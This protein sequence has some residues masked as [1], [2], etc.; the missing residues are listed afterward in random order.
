MDSIFVKNM[1][2]G[3]SKEVLFEQLKKNIEDNK[4]D[5]LE[6]KLVRYYRLACEAYNGVR[7]YSGEEY[8]THTLNVATILAE[9]EASAEQVL[10]GLFCDVLKK[11]NYSKI[12]KEI[13]EN[14]NKIILKLDTEM[15]PEDIQI[16]KIAERLHN[17]RTIEYMDISK[18]V[19]KAKET[20]DKYMP[21][22]RKIGNQ[23]LID[24]LNDLALKY[25]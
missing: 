22:A 18:R 17:M 21:I 20:L 24:E 15:V 6:E 12:A 16:I 19:G 25:T 3:T 23:K 14:I 2:V 9:C 11:G 5:I 4:I 13:D 8:V 7:R 1:Q 10:A